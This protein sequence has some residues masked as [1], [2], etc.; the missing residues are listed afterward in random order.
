M[1]RVSAASPPT[2]RARTTC[3]AEVARRRRDSAGG[4][5][6]AD[7]RA[8]RRRDARARPGADARLLCGPALV[9][10]DASRGVSE[11]GLVSVDAALYYA[12]ED[13][14]RRRGGSKQRGREV[15]CH[16]WLSYTP[17]TEHPHVELHPQTHAAD[18]PDAARRADADVRR[19]P[20]RARRPRRTDV[21]ELRSGD[22]G[23]APFGMRRTTASTLSRSRN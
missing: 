4:G 18:D 2:S 17:V 21:H 12:A 7:A 9:F 13:W 14:I 23:R 16:R 20:V 10:G 15:I 3:R 11:Y 6:G 19:D 5:V 22:G 1:F 8:T